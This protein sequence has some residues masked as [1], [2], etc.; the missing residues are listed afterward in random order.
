MYTN[1][2]CGSM[3]SYESLCEA[4]DGLV[5]VS[6]HLCTVMGLPL[7]ECAPISGKLSEEELTTPSV[8][9]SPGEYI[10]WTPYV[11]WLHL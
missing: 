10:S 1:T 5:A 4:V 9:S 11:C 3:V 8:P 2:V 6:N 7:R